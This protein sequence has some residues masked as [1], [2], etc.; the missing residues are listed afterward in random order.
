MNANE[1]EYKGAS[2]YQVAGA[3]AYD[4]DNGNDNSVTLRGGGERINAQLK[5]RL[6][7]HLSMAGI[8]IVEAR[9]NSFA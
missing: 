6:S 8:E 5:E 4:N 3:Y 7:E 9:I 2:I 1:Y